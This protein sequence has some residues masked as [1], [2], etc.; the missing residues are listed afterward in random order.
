[1]AS[2]SEKAFP[3]LAFHENKCVVTVQRQFPRKYEKRPQVNH[4]FVLGTSPFLP[5]AVCVKAK[6]LSD[7]L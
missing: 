6:A 2:G 1:M 7:P 3:V 4:L 5:M